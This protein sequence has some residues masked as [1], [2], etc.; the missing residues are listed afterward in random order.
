MRFTFTLIATVVFAF[1]AQALR[2]DEIA[3]VVNKNV[4]DGR[5]IAKEYAQ[6]RHIP[7]GRIIELDLPATDDV[8]FQ[9]YETNVVPVVRE[10]LAKHNLLQ[11]VRCLVTFYGV[12][13]RIAPREN[14]PADNAEIETIQQEMRTASVQIAKTVAQLEEMATKLD[15]RFRS[16][17]GNDLGALVRRLEITRQFIAQRIPSIKDQKQRDAYLAQVNEIASKLMTPPAPPAT[18]ASGQPATQMTQ[19]LS[20]EMSSLEARRYEPEARARQREIARQVSGP[21]PYARLLD[22]Q[23]G[24]LLPDDSQAAFDNELALVDWA[25]YSRTK[26][27]INPLYYRVSERAPPVLMVSRLDAQTPATVRRMIATSIEVEQHGLQGQVL[28]DSWGKAGKEQTDYAKFDQMLVDFAAT[29]RQKTKLSLTFDD[30]PELVPTGSAKDIAV[31]CGW[32]SPNEFVS[33]GTFTPVAI[34]VHIASYTLT[35]LHAPGSGDWVR[36]MLNDGAVA[37]FGAVSEPYLHSFPNPN[38]F[39]PLIL[40]GKV[41]LA[42]AYWRTTPLVS[43]RIVLVGDPLYTPY[44]Q[45]PAIGIADLPPNLRSLF[46][47]H[48]PAPTTVQA[49]PADNR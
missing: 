48:P 8:S 18:N 30:K 21:L 49:A 27:Q 31:Y 47:D 14:T 6:A 34:G 13:L 7:D 5:E 41:Q 16:S 43:W 37:S 3:L 44:K 39:F 36:Q 4:A 12:P 2:P 11:N 1:S 25:L 32:Y 28:I 23:L 15:P 20:S 29:V 10:F 26:W 42:E 38:D 19:A 9:Q 33:P 40:T 24:Y 35:T 45:N 17:P 46:S 22:T